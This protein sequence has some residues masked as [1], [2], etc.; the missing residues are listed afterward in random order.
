MQVSSCFFFSFKIHVFL[1]SRSEPAKQ[2]MVEVETVLRIWDK[3]LQWRVLG[4]G[5]C[6]ENLRIWYKLKEWHCWPCR[7][8]LTMPC[9]APATKPNIFMTSWNTFL[10]LLLLLVWPAWE[11]S[12]NAVQL[13]IHMW[14]LSRKQQQ[15]H[16]HE[17]VYFTNLLLRLWDRWVI[18]AS[19]VK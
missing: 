11:A 4:Y 14:C 19:G 10:L 7:N 16:L 13:M 8:K 1:A 18:F 5:N 6:T 15:T 9:R 3:L 17:Y 12:L 2:D